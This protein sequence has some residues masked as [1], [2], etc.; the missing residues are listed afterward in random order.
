MIVAPISQ[1]FAPVSI[2]N[3]SIAGTD[4]PIAS[5]WYLTF[6]IMTTLWTHDSDWW[7]CVFI[8]LNAYAMDMPL[9][10]QG[11]CK[12]RAGD[13]CE[14]NKRWQMRSIVIREFWNDL[15][16]ARWISIKQSVMT[17]SCHATLFLQVSGFDEVARQARY[18]ELFRCLL[19]PGLVN[20]IRTA[21]KGTSRVAVKYSRIRQ[22]HCWSTGRSQVN[23]VD[24]IQ[25][26]NKSRSVSVVFQV[27]PSVSGEQQYRQYCNTNQSRSLDYYT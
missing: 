19:D 25:I 21:K 7:A 15:I 18:R 17:R 9:A 24:R 12:M 11:P 13:V 1:R 16:Q 22:R 8:S 5:A 4:A 2:R 27:F 20:Q 14:K 26:S 3:M 6:N 23:Q 10:C